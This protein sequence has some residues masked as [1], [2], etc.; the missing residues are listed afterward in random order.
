MTVPLHWADL[1]CSSAEIQVHSNSKHQASTW[2]LL[3]EIDKEVGIFLNQQTTPSTNTQ[4]SGG[5]DFGIVHNKQNNQVSF[6][7]EPVQFENEIN[8]TP[9]TNI[10]SQNMWRMPSAIN[11]D[12]SGLPHST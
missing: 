12:S 4:A 6:L 10:S 8:Y 7:E 1:V 5:V 2:Q 11:L 3:P 9:A